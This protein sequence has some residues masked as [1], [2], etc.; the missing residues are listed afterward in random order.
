LNNLFFKHKHSTTLLSSK[1]IYLYNLIKI[2]KVAEIGKLNKLRVVKELDFGI[3][4]DGLE[5]GEI[6]MPRRYVPEN[7]KPEDII[8]AF[9]YFDSEDRIIA[10]TEKPYA[11]VGEFALLE[12]ISVNSVGAFLNW[13]LPKDLL[14]PFNEQK[15]KMAEGQSYIVYV[16]IDHESKRIVAS[17]KL[18]KFLDNLP[19]EYEIGQ[20]VDLLI[21]N[22]TDIGYKAIIDKKHWGIL[23]QNEVFQTINKGQKIKGFIKK[24]RED[25]KIDLTLQKPG[26]EKVG[27]LLQIIVDALELHDGFISVTDKSPADMIYQLFGM[28]KKNYKK[29]IG[30]LYKEKSVALE[31]KGIRL[32]KKG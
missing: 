23:Y 8:E 30:A 13:G 32:I 29:A 1:I 18:D 6:L 31:D 12:A 26:Y 19:P 3:Y 2:I 21:G 27:D 14:V 28:S 5:H 25:E 22:Q 4:L 11:M 15:Q 16:Y 9:V 24:I 20:E 10:T 7:C 17:A